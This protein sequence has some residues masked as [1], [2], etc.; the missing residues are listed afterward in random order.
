M[1][2]LLPLDMPDVVTLDM[3]IDELK[4]ERSM[5]A[6]VYPRL[7]AAGTL[8]PSAAMRNNQRLDAAIAT[9]ERLKAG[10]S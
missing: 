3:Q 8:K 5:R 2:A 9:L 4:R 7:L 6:Q 10:A 1:T